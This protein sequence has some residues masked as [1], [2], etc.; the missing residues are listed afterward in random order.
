MQ[1]RH[2][3]KNVQYE[4]FA[5]RNSSSVETHLAIALYV[6]QV[7]GH[8]TLPH[9]TYMEIRVLAFTW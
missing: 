6:V 3:V 7:R 1:A 5:V 4:Q 9:K 8:D 2:N